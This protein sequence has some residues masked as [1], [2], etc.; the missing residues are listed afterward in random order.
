MSVFMVYSQTLVDTYFYYIMSL[1]DIKQG[2]ISSGNHAFS[3]LYKYFAFLQY[4]VP[5]FCQVSSHQEV[6]GGF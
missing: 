5:P 3:K 2:I 1:N 4:F 6:C